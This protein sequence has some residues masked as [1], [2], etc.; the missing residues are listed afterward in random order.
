M[1]VKQ[2][3]V[4]NK[5]IIKNEIKS[6]IEYEKSSWLNLIPE[7]SLDFNV[8]LQ[9]HLENLFT[10]FICESTLKKKTL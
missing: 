3:R 1:Q 2:P 10:G 6:K 7:W 5:T 9:G 8:I 4:N